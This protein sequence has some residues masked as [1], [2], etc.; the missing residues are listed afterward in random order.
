MNPTMLADLGAEREEKE[1]KCL[2]PI[3]NLGRPLQVLELLS[4]WSLG[5]AEEIT[6]ICILMMLLSGSESLW[7]SQTVRFDTLDD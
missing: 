5:N 3:V 6:V 1:S 2:G 4:D 7:F